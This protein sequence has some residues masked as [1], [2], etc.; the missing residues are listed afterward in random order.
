MRSSF[1]VKIRHLPGTGHADP[2]D[3]LFRVGECHC[4]LSRNPTPPWLIIAFLLAVIQAANITI[5]L[6]IHRKHQA[7]FERKTRPSKGRP[8]TLV[9][10]EAVPYGIV[11]LL[12]LTIM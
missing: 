8:G 1:S 7:L 6:H 11:R 4:L 9:S 3:M 5:S 12:A 2:A 10:S